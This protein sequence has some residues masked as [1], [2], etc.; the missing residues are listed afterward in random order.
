MAS[1]TGTFFDSVKGVEYARKV[2][3]HKLST[4]WENLSEK[5]WGNLGERYSTKALL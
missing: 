1:N 4:R 5:K 2:H 3:T